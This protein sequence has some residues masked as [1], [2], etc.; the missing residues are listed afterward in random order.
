MR[1]TF[2]ILILFTSTV[3]AQTES[4]I[5]LFKDLN[6][7]RLANGVKA[8]K[9]D[10]LLYSKYS[11]KQLRK[12]VEADSIYHSDACEETVM[13]SNSLPFKS[14]SSGLEFNEFLKRF[15]N[16]SYDFNPSS[17]DNKRDELMNYVTKY[18]IF[19]FHNSK[20]HRASMLSDYNYFG[21]AGL[22]IKDVKFHRG[23]KER[24][25]SMPI[26]LQKHFKYTEMLKSNYKFKL[27]ACIN[28]N[29]YKFSK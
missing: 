4:D 10:S 3:Q 1:L 12:M 27:F 9:F 23:T 18:I 25:E 11:I 17:E 7:Y 14:D 28:F 13:S 22:S 29:D 24:I 15:Y 6:T 16:I 26:G 19:I 20:H 5:L 21:S 2:I 8:L